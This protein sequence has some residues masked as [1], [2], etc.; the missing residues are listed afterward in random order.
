MMTRK[1]MLE[2]AEQTVAHIFH[3]K[4]H[5]NPSHTTTWWIARDEGGALYLY[6]SKPHRHNRHKSAKVFISNYERGCDPIEDEMI[7]VP[8]K[9]FP[10]VTWENSPQEVEI[11]LKLK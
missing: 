7:K 6:S 10:E 11:T 5:N 3:R 2:W 4:P 9:L 1:E 8:R